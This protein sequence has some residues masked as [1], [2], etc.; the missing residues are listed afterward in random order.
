M[1]TEEQKY[2]KATDVIKTGR[3]KAGKY[4]AGKA[5]TF[6]PKPPLGVEGKQGFWSDENPQ[7]GFWIEFSH[8]GKKETSI[9]VKKDGKKFKQTMNEF[10]SN[11][12]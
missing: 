12:I 11:C 7:D 4:K 6:I 5:D 10:I 1:K 2:I 3:R 9:V 8:S